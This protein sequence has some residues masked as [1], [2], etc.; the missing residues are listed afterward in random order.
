MNSNNLFKNN[1][2]ISDEVLLWG[3][4]DKNN[5]KIPKIIWIY[6]DSAERNFLVERCISQ[7]RKLC[8]DYD[9]TIL[10]R[11]NVIEYVDLSK[12]NKH[13]YL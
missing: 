7:V 1:I 4:G 9:I 8:P 13:L 2:T 11:K 12:I 10:N 6:W 3:K 5:Q